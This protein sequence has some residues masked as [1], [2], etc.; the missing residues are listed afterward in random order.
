MDQATF[1]K[2]LEKNLDG[3]SDI[4]KEEI[5]NDFNEYFAAAKEE[6]ESE[7]EI[8]Q[9]LGNPEQLAKE[10]RVERGV[11]VG[12]ESRKNSEQPGAMH[13]VGT[14]IGLFF[15]NVTIMLGVI[16]GIAGILIGLYIAG[17]TFLFSP[18]VFVIDAIR[19]KT[20][21]FFD[22]FSSIALVGVG[23]I[24]IRML[25]PATKYLIRLFKQYVAWNIRVIKGGN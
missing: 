25:I 20:F 11:D 22:F 13:V 8:C 16:L 2:I 18:I 10:I 9:S 3:L 7:S 21:E 1:L 19:L 5:R 4:E 15:L 14:T 23:I 24:L 6:G 12:K 17:I